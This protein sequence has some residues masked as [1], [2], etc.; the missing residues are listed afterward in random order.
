MCDKTEPPYD[1]TAWR[2]PGLEQ[3][4]A[5]AL[6]RA[7][8]YGTHENPPDFKGFDG[9]PQERPLIHIPYDVDVSGFYRDQQ[10]RETFESGPCPNHREASA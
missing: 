9:I 5:E 1:C 3:I 2:I 7:L 6:D 8:F 10:W 4:L